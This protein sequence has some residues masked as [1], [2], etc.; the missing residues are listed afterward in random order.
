MKKIIQFVLLL[1]LIFLI[2]VFYNEYFKEKKEPIIQQKF[3]EESVISQA[4]NN[5]IQNLEY[6]INIKKDNNYKLSS[7]K[8]EIFY[9]DSVELIKMYNVKAIFTD[10]NNTQI[11]VKSD[12]AIY[13]NDNYNTIFE[14]NITIIYLDNIIYGDKLNLD[15]ER[16]SLII[17]G[18]V[19]Y[20]GVNGNLI[21]DNIELDLISRQINIFMNQ[22]NKKVIINSKE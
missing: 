11:I 15:L 7:E 14:K 13:N 3:P 4:D 17:Y 18:N 20:E 6:E 16:N 8:S 19:K 5:L 12:E 1:I 21:A 2:F 22:E 10:K 9:K